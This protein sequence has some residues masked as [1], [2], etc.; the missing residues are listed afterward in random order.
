[1]KLE[2][3][4]EKRVK[5]SEGNDMLVYATPE[6]IS[7]EPVPHDEVVLVANGESAPICQ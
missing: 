4:R 1:M 6:V 7:P 5:K 3:N 2:V